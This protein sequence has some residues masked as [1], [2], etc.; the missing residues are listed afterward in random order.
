M[1]ELY[2]VA[3]GLKRPIR[4]GG[5]RV[6]MLTLCR[7]RLLGLGPQGLSFEVEQAATR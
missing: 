4:S 7:T 5:S 1:I 3:G 2:P 6:A